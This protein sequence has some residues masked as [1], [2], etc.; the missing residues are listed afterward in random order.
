MRRERNHEWSGEGRPNGDEK[1]PT[2]SGKIHAEEL[3]YLSLRW[4]AS[5]LVLRTRSL[6]LV[7]LSVQLSVVLSDATRTTHGAERENTGQ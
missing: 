4:S 2:L 1:V 3:V 6:V 5:S 7:Q